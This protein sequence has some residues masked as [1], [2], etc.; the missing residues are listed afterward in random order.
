MKKE[1]DDKFIPCTKCKKYFPESEIV[2]AMYL[3][4][5]KE[6]AK[7]KAETYLKSQKEQISKEKAREE[8][9]LEKDVKKIIK[10]V[11]KEGKSK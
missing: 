8:K 11:L 1:K 3:P 6:C 2:F 4:Y 9:E 7:N 10:K 5:C